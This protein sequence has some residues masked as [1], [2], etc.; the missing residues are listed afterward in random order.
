MGG[1]IQKRLEVRIGIALFLVVAA[2][3][4]VFTVID[5]RNMRSAVIH[6]AR[7]SLSAVAGSV[8]GNVNASM[9][10]GYHQDVQRIIDEARLSFGIDRI[11]LY[12]HQAKERRSSG[13]DPGL[14]PQAREIPP[15]VRRNISQGDLTEINE[16]RSYLSYYSPIP[17]EASCFRCHG[18]ENALNGIL[19]IDFTLSRI[20][21]VIADRRNSMLL[22]AGFMI[23][24]LMAALVLLLRQLVHNPVEEL[25]KAMSLAEAGR[26][27]LSLSM[28]GTD[29]L[30]DLKRRFLTMLDRI[31]T[32]HAANVEKEKELAH[33]REVMRFRAELQTMFNAMPDGVLL[34]DRSRRIVQGNP[35][36]Y[37]LL[38]ALEPLGGSIEPDCIRKDCCPFQGLEEALEKGKIAEGQCAIPHPD[39]VLHLHS[40]CAPIMV[41][42]T[43]E[44]VVT[45]VRDITERV[46]TERELEERTAELISANKLLSQ[47]AVT[48]G[49]TQV[50]NRRSFDEVLSREIKRFNRRNYTHLS[51]M[52]ID[53]DHFKM[54][55][56][57]F[58]HL[59]GDMVLRETAKM[60]RENVRETDTVA[61]FGGEEFVIVMPDTHLD[62]AHVRAEALRKKIEERILHGVDG[63]EIRT[64]ISIGIA[65]YSSGAAQDLLKEADTALYQAKRSGRNNVVVKR[66]GLMVQD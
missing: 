16:R 38:P 56:D 43:V 13:V 32:L 65:A 5:I 17:N 63:R 40:I 42:G 55:N 45:V 8:K 29:E 62:G 46:K 6:T 49:L 61:R 28:R 26:S 18:A 37:A 27:D 54:L 10:K 59:A 9:R 4:G 24:A 51:L 21:R 47:L 30:S 52:M 25:R 39:G 57:R 19:R 2:I 64:T 1:F 15:S 23:A 53:I 44:Y 41:D 7:Q 48:D 58:G 20:E 31:N 50:H 60:L 36:V 11:L 14:P 66:P 34:V 12:D 33:N 35:R 22:W 3:I